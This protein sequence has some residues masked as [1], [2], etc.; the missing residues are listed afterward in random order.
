M[1]AYGYDRFTGRYTG[2]VNAWADQM[3]PGEYILPANATFTEPPEV[4]EGK[5]R[6]WDG[7]S[8]SQVDA[9][10]VPT[11]PAV[12]PPTPAQIVRSERNGKLM[13][14]D[15]TQL[16][17][18]PLATKALWATYRQAL[19]DVPQQSGFPTTFTWPIAPGG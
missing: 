18:V 15:W 1:I 4:V 14:S 10:V 17:D 9:P 11:P 13:D 5:N 8:W 3:A 16:P 7:T 12:T 19:R 6:V 2:R